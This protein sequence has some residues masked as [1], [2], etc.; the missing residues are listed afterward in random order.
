[1]LWALQAD[2][3]AVYDAVALG[4]SGVDRHQIV[5]MKVDA[6]CAHFAQ[7]GY[8]VVGR[9]RRPHRRTKWIAALIGNGP[10]TKG[11]F[12]FGEGLELIAHV[13]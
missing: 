2:R 11:K 4:W 5:V 10:E 7:H 1:M 9:K 12:V 6:P 3:E 8:G 13:L